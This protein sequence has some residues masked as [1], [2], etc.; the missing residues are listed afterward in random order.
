[1]N[2]FLL[3]NSEPKTTSRRI[4]RKPGL[5]VEAS[6][7]YDTIYTDARCVS[8][9][10][11]VLTSLLFSHTLLSYTD[12]ITSQTKRLMNLLYFLKEAAA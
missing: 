8:Q 1:M 2:L 3:C 6:Q 11:E 4:I 10:N 7:H 5:T 12:N 9:H